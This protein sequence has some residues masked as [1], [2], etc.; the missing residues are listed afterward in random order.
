[1]NSSARIKLGEHKWDDCQRHSGKVY[2]DTRPG[3]VWE[4]TDFSFARPSITRVCD[5]CSKSFPARVH[6]EI[7]TE[8]TAHEQ[9]DH[10]FKPKPPE[11]GADIYFADGVVAAQVVAIV[12]RVESVRVIFGEEEKETDVYEIVPSRPILGALTSLIR[13]ALVVVSVKV[14]ADRDPME[15]R[16]NRWCVCRG[17]LRAITYSNGFS[18]GT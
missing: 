14:N 18:A 15:F 4:I 2:T 8:E 17:P 12:R 10:R 9:R 7:Y 5:K 1:M 6:P 11:P 13:R 3:A 16:K